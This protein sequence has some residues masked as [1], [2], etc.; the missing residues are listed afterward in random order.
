MKEEARK[1]VMKYQ[2]ECYKALYYHFT[3]YAEFVEQ[4]QRA[5]ETQ[6]EIVD[7]AK[8]NFKSAKSVL[9]EADKTLR[10]LRQLNYS[11][12]D[13]ERRQLKM[14]SDEEMGNIPED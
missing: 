9:D 12:F 10:S 8:T 5:I 7:A 14:F 11:D 3:N 6:L 2:V 1:T 13:A 4:K